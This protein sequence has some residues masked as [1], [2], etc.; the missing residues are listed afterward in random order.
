M[1][2]QSKHTPGPWIAPDTFLNN[3]PNRTYLRQKAYGGAVIADLGE[4][5]HV[6]QADARLIAAAPELLEACK[7]LLMHSGC[8]TGHAK[9]DRWAKACAEARAI[10]AKAEGQP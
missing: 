3:Q 7:A 6:N 5:S 10:I 1:S 9:A 2:N 8:P 4:T